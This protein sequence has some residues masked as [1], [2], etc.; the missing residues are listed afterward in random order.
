MI[1]PGNIFLV[2]VLA[3]AGVTALMIDHIAP[4]VPEEERVT[5]SES[6]MGRGCSLTSKSGFYRLVYRQSEFDIIIKTLTLSLF[7]TH[8]FNSLRSGLI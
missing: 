1:S 2:C 3:T 8:F 4:G 6:R 5:P 7:C